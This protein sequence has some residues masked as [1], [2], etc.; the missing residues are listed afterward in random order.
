MIDAI[1]LTPGGVFELPYGYDITAFEPKDQP[2]NFQPALKWQLMAGCAAVGVMPHEVLFDYEFPE[3]LGRYLNLIQ[4]RRAS[5]VHRMM[6][7]QV[8]DPMVRWF[9]DV[10]E[11]SG[12]WTP[13]ADLEA[14]DK[15]R[16]TWE[17]D[18]TPLASFNQELKALQE[19]ARAGL[20]S[21]TYIQRTMFQTDPTATDIEIAREK[22]REQA[23]AAMSER[24]LADATAD[25]EKEMAVGD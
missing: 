8:G 7:F 12:R 11:A 9:V 1:S 13:P 15:Y 2:A 19:A 21:K 20:I 5:V 16:H 22:A 14:A 18:L 3:R 6:E 4:E 17:W 24:L 23:I 25:L 10:A